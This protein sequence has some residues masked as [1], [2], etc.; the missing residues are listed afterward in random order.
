MTV[1]WPEPPPAAAVE[2][3]WVGPGSG[4]VEWAVKADA[5]N[6]IARWLAPTA[7]V[8]ESLRVRDQATGALDVDLTIMQ[9]TAVLLKGDELTLPPMAALEAID[10]IP[11]GSG[12]PALRA[13]VLGALLHQRGHHY[14][15]VEQNATRC[16]LRGR[17]RDALAEQP[18]EEARWD[19]DRAK[20][21]VGQRKM[22]DPSGNWRKQPATML[23]WRALA[24]LARK[25]APEVMLGLPVVDVEVD[26]DPE[27]FPDGAAP[28]PRGQRPRGRAAGRGTRPRAAAAPSPPAAPTSAAP[29][30]AAAPDGEQPP[31]IEDAQ[32]RAL[33]AG[34]RDL[35]ITGRDASLRMV[36]QWI[37]RQVTSSNDL[38]KEEA[39][40]A[41][42]AIT[43]ARDQQA[44]R[45]AAQQAGE[46][47]E[48][49]QAGPDEDPGP[50]P[51]AP[52]E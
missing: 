48:A 24:D 50:D 8:P 26:D 41:L 49:S 46:A 5:A 14:W 22:G 15:T 36:S 6:R 2:P 31:M 9:V 13:K 34:M 51:P 27:D 37:G 45:A 28:A 33:W 40:K 11:P 16:T 7:F 17:A 30:A 21:L 47:A 39:G 42:D 23:Y 38:T 4:L 44:A 52:D 32:R 25:I 20:A 35:G 18:D 29:G 19:I 12:T 1:A 3:S 10:I 43:A